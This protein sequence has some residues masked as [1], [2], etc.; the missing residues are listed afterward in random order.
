MGSHPKGIELLDGSLNKGWIV[1]K[2]SRLEVPTQGTFHAYAGTGQ[3][4]RTDIGR[5][6]IK[7]H[8]L[9]MDPRAHNPFQIRRKNL[10]PVKVFTKVRPRFLGVY[11]PHTYPAL[12]EARELPQQGNRFAILLHVHILDIGSSNPQRIADLRNARDDFGVMLLVL[13]VLRE[14]G[15]DRNSAL[16]KFLFSLSSCSF[17][18][19]FDF[20]FAHASR[21]IFQSLLIYCA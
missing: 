16:L 20:F 6:Q 18:F 2:D 19:H 17:D 5:F 15:H 8:H 7:N 12:Q 21:T 14:D 13:D 1:G 9:E 11:Q 10:E 4:R 3:I